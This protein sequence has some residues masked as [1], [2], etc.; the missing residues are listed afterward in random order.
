MSN[1]KHENEIKNIVEIWALLEVMVSTI[2]FVFTL[3]T[4]MAHAN[5]IETLCNKLVEKGNLTPSEAQ[6]VLVET[7]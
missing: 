7:R 4:L 2:I 1:A 6:T 3:T 5:E